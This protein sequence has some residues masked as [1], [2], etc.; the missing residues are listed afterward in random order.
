MVSRHQINQKRCKRRNR[1]FKTLIITPPGTATGSSNTITILPFTV[2]EG[3]SLDLSP[4]Y[5]RLHSANEVGAIL[6]HADKVDFR[7]VP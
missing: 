1:I 6:P 7:I 2:K 4:W 5:D 3:A